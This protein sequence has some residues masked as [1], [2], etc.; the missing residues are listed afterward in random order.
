MKL[1]YFSEVAYMA[2]FDRIETNRDKYKSRTTW[3]QEVFKDTEYCSESKIEC[4]DFKLIN[5]GN[6][7]EDDH[8]NTITIYNA[9][10]KV[11]TPNQACN[12]YLWS[13]LAHVDFWEYCRDRWPIEKNASIATRY[14]C[15]DSRTGLT[16]NALSRLWW[17][18]YLTYDEDNPLEPF[19]RT[20]LLLK[21]SDLCQ[22]IIQHS[23]SMN[24]T[25]T[26]GILD[27]MQTYYDEGHAF[28]IEQ[29]RKLIKFI[30]RY[31]AVTSM[32]LFEREEIKDLVI[33]KMIKFE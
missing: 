29:E 20:S 11:L 31:G 19:H 27:G 21:Y 16:L 4:A 5:S 9:L 33:K 6:H 14:F 28:D 24:K 25:V 26:L 1:R 3:I 8:I 17:Y 18:G 13:Y 22:N 12:K 30:N 32:D 10:G 2:L 15:T 7:T 23:F